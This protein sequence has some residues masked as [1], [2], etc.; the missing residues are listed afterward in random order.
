[1]SR[2]IN[3][4]RGVAEIDIFV[5]SFFCEHISHRN[6]PN[7]LFAQFLRVKT[8]LVQNASVM[9]RKR[10]MDGPQFAEWMA[11]KLKFVNCVLPRR[12]YEANC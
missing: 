7:V 4:E 10:L 3:R 9:S 8:R 5:L 1:M 11:P 2:G 6:V 12:K